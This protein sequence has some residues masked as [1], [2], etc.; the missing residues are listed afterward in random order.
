MNFFKQLDNEYKNDLRAMKLQW[1]GMK[2]KIATLKIEH[3]ELTEQ[4]DNY[5]SLVKQTL[6]NSMLDDLDDDTERKNLL[7]DLRFILGEDANDL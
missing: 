1:E 7:A 2:L 4:L 6:Y 5:L 3:P